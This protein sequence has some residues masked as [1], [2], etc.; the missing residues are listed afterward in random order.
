MK[1]NIMKSAA[2]A[3]CLGSLSWA[4]LAR[5]DGWPISIAGTWSIVANQSPGVLVI[6][7]P[8]SSLNCRPITGTIYGT[9][10]IQGFYCPFSGRISFARLR[11]GVAIQNYQGNLSVVQSGSPLRLGGSFSVINST[12]GSP[13]EYNFSGTK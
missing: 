4:G 10:Q 6:N 11:N 13:G 9:D 5:A 8:S 1:S 3:V 2:L 12:G 7:Q